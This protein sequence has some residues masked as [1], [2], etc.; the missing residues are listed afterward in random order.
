M[1]Q[2]SRQR[3]EKLIALLTNEHVERFEKAINDAIED[4]R[5]YALKEKEKAGEYPKE[6]SIPEHYIKNKLSSVL[7]IFRYP[8]GG[9]ISR[10]KLP[11]VINVCNDKNVFDGKLNKIYNSFFEEVT[12]ILREVGYLKSNG[13]VIKCAV[14]YAKRWRKECRARA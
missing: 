5:N 12:R 11:D 1:E 8:Y 13:R 10:F 3:K 9:A 2:D 14:C 4:I 6:G 7:D